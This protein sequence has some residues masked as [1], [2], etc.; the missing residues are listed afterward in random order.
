MCETTSVNDHGVKAVTDFTVSMLDVTE[1]RITIPILA[2]ALLSLVQSVMRET[3][4][5]F[6]GVFCLAG[7][8]LSG[9]TLLFKLFFDFERGREVDIN[10]DATPVA[11]IRKIGN[12]RDAVVVVDDFKP[13]STKSAENSQ[14]LILDRV[15]RMCSDD[16]HGYQKAGRNNSTVAIIPHCIV[17][18][19]AEE[20]RL[21]V[22]STLARLLI[23]EMTKHS[24]NWKV[25]TD[26][27]ANHES[28]K[29]FLMN[30]I[31]Y[32][33]AQ[34]VRK[35]CENLA[36][37]FLKERNTLRNILLEKDI[38]VDNRTSD[39]C[40]WL[41]LSFDE[42]LKYALGVEAID[43]ERFESYKEESRQIFL[44]FMEEQ[45][46]RINDLDDVTR[47]FTGLRFLLDTAEA[48]IDPLRARNSSFASEDSKTAIGFS[49]AGCIYLKNDVA[50]RNVVSYFKRF[51]K[52]F[53][54]SESMLRKMLSNN[55]HLIQNPNNPKSPIHRLSVNRE[56]YQCIKF[57]EATFRKLL[58]GGKNDDIGND[59]EFQS[60][61][62]ARHN[63]DNI[64]GR[65]D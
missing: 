25:Y 43:H 50:F 56:N 2:V 46:E 53:V 57:A 15:I 26:C 30:Y 14:T 27:L 32:I 38:I 62:V 65:R 47:F 45:A 5:F 7:P 51:G 52:D 61:R 24:M 33:S 6:K 58:N 3:G 41:S 10:F 4:D 39:M 22:K 48:R 16:S 55:G 1:H 42:F 31:R 21:Q 59:S 40:T 9:K 13:T 29:A 8:C 20:I 36:K 19:T 28:Y 54:M 63:A 17:A 18:I 64:L 34:G 23:E 35:Y 37:L 49:K 44:N 60:D 12:K 11:I